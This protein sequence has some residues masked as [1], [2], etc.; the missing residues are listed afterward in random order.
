MHSD[1]DPVIG[2]KS[3]I[4]FMLVI[5]LAMWL[6]T[7]CGGT[8]T[9]QTIKWSGTIHLH[10]DPDTMNNYCNH[11]GPRIGRVKGCYDPK[12]NSIHTTKWDDSNM[13]HEMWHALSY[14]GEP[15]LIVDEGHDHF[16]VKHEFIIRRKGGQ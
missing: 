15:R 9:S 14:R 2:I 1:L 12:T 8:V 7:G 6:L 3:G 11:L 5:W 4:L 10:K 13:G 16:K